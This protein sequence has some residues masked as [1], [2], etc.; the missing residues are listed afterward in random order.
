[1][2][3][4]N[5]DGC[6]RC[7][8]CQ[9]TCPTD[10]ID[11]TPTYIQHCDTCGGEPKCAEVCPESA[12]KFEYFTVEEDQ[13][14]QPRLTFNSALCTQC[15][16]CQEVCPQRTCVVTG[17]KY[18]EVKGYC[19]MCRK[20]VEICPVQVIGIPDIIEPRE[21]RVDLSGKGPIYI[22][23]CV[24]CGTCV[25]PC[26]VNAITLPNGIGESIAIDADTCIKC[27]VC[28]Q[29][30]PWNA[31]FISERYPVKREKEILDF[32]LT[33][34]K[35]IGCNTCVE[36][37]PG[38]FIKIDESGLTVMLPEICAA[39]SLCVEV[40][41]TDA[42]DIDVKWGESHPV[43]A[44][45]LG[46]DSEKC[47]YIGACANKCPTEAIRVVTKT[48]MLC[49]EMT[50]TDEEPSLVNCIRCG[51]CASVCPED[52]LSIGSIEKMVDGKLVLR[53]RIE[54]NPSKCTKC[55]DCVPACPYNLIKLTEDPKLPI[56]G[57]CTLCDQCI[58]ACPEHAFYS[59]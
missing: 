32:T 53:D 45:G 17:E 51:A 19:V 33:K 46:W 31:V 41:P 11:V 21:C 12:L 26:P 47:E 54:Y 39:C 35:C 20:C 42:L 5:E 37:C 3:I 24:G 57:F 29:T 34:T 1:M 16:K 7:G 59:K 40:C 28:S 38:D 56:K 36:A 22:H 27:G 4:F 58:E 44:E 50:Q 2:I 14:D 18:H 52:A 55:G 25:D 48:G 13:L 15:G 10:A 43:D 6:I 30:C 9:G 8:A 23:N 49:P